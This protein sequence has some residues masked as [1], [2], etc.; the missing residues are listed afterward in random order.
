M[1]PSI[2]E[3]VDP[4]GLWQTLMN[5]C[6]RE[7]GSQQ[8]T[9]EGSELTADCGLAANEEIFLSARSTRVSALRVHIPFDVPDPRCTA[10]IRK[11]V[12]PETWQS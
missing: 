10:L 7:E 3:S 2:A 8:L 11:W 9:E 6:E 4:A 1:G 12:T 5:C